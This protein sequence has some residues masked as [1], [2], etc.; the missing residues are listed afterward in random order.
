MTLRFVLA[1]L[2]MALTLPACSRAQD[3]AAGKAYFDNNCALCHDASPQAQA[4]EG[5]ALFGVA[6]RKVGGVADYDYSQPLK[7]ANAAG[8][9][10]D[11]AALNAFLADPQAAMPGTRMPVAI[12]DAGDR[13]NVV[14]YL[15]SLSGA[16]AT[17]QSTTSGADTFDWRQDAPGV[18]HE[19]TVADLPKPFATNSAGNNPSVVAAD[20]GVM[21]KVPAGFTV[22]LFADHLDGPRLVRTAPNG[23]LYVVLSGAGRI[24]VYRNQGGQLATTAQTFATGLNRP[25][26]IDF[27]P[28]KDSK[29][30]YVAN[31]GSVVRIP[32]AGGPAET[33]VD[34]LSSTGGHNTR[35]LVFSPDG[36]YMYISIGSASN[37]AE[38]MGK[39]PAG[40]VAGRALGESWGGE[41]GRALVL[42]FTPDGKNRQVYATGLRNCVG[43]GFRPG[44]ED[45]YCSVNER[46]GLGDNLVPDYFT[47]VGQGQFFGWPWYYLGDHADPRQAG[48]RNDLEDR[49]TVP[50]IWFVSHSAPLGFTFYV[51]PAGAAKPFPAD[52]TGNAFIALHGSWNRSVRTGSKVVRVRFEDGKPV[53]GYEDFMTGFVIDDKRVSGRPVA[54][55][56][57]PDGALYVSD[58]A[59][60]KIWRISAE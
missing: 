41:D 49:I 58:D 40:F 60:D 17:A 23:D 26:G 27:Y 51:P 59:G 42:R 21:P 38:G 32:I 12:A 25:F 28:A 3:V 10:W 45:L 53:G 24:L 5:P 20:T 19:V 36:Q 6:H 14:A 29:Y 35:N 48:V 22:S 9:T 7:D 43:L 37:V 16:K 52:Y 30:L 50:D 13:K 56:V 31:V 18:R 46:D 39:A 1:C 57:G 34:D 55:A 8:K 15:M 44:S 33:V 4:F 47:R 11:A 54:I 2:V